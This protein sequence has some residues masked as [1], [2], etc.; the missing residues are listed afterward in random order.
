MKLYKMLPALLLITTLS[1]VTL[2]VLAQP[3]GRDAGGRG[4]PFEPPRMPV[5]MTLDTNGDGELSGEEISAAAEAL[6]KVGQERRREAEPRGALTRVRRARRTGPAGRSAR[7]RT[8][9]S[10]SR[11][12]GTAPGRAEQRV[13][14]RNVTR[15][16]RRAQHPASA[17]TDHR[18][19]RGGG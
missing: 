6:K 15:R 11:R 5:M 4:R 8:G 18:R 17:E 2:G 14:R 1:A 13:P 7:R 9:W 16:Q 12:A 19:N 3:P 10:W